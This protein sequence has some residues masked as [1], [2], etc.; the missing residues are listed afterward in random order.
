MTMKK[1]MLAAGA[2]IAV[3]VA[4]DAGAALATNEIDRT[5]P[6]ENEDGPGRCVWDARH[7][8]NG[9]GHS[10]VWRNDGT[11]IFISHRRA[12]RL[13]TTNN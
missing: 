8:G 6:C 3:M 5:P 1:T 11:K 10:L 4:H 9:L 12:H 13:M 2:L 7:M